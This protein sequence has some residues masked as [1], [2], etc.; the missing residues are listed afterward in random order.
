MVSPRGAKTALYFQFWLSYQLLYIAW[1]HPG[2]ADFRLTDYES[3]ERWWEIIF[4]ASPV[5]FPLA[6]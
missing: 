3:I 1:E 6:S 2:W 5:T 4:R